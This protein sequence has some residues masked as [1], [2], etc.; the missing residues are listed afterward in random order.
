MY[1]KSKSTKV[2]E[3]AD[4]MVET[5]VQQGK[6]IDNQLFL[7]YN[8]KKVFRF[9]LLHFVHATLAQGAHAMVTISPYWYQ[10]IL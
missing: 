1:A 4:L 10:C 9:L 5:Y 8:V 2:S 6:I 7:G 3:N